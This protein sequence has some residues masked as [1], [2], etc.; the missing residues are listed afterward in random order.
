MAFPQ[1]FVYVGGRSPGPCLPPP[2]N[3]F[4]SQATRVARAPQYLQPSAAFA[5]SASV[6]GVLGVPNLQLPHGADS[7][8]VVPQFC[9][10]A[11]GLMDI[12]LRTPRELALQIL[13]WFQLILLWIAYLAFEARRRSSAAVLVLML[14]M[15]LGLLLS[16]PRRLGTMLAQLWGRGA[17]LW[18][19]HSWEV[20]Q[21]RQYWRPTR[22]YVPFGAL[23]SSGL[24]PVDSR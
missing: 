7:R 10:W 18:G 14:D 12:S 15:Q 21:L 8:T 20:V 23:R 17:A 11:Q 4:P 3:V 16:C 6:W 13:P 22:G 5:P 24:L 9:S 19:S 2:L 1:G